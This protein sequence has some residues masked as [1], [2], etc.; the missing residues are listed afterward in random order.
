MKATLLCLHGL[1][2]NKR[3]ICVV[4]LGKFYLGNG[5]PQYIAQTRLLADTHNAKHGLYDLT[6]GS[7]FNVT[8]DHKKKHG[9]L[10]TDASLEQLTDNI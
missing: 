3:T 8:L 1:A 6:M 9:S 2:Q 7:Q 4:T 5:H 10:K